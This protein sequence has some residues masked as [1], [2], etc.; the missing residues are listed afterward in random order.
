MEF[1][2][3][4]PKPEK[5]E[6][7]KQKKIKTNYN[8][9]RSP[10]ILTDLYPYEKGMI[11]HEIYHGRKNREICCDLGLWVWLWHDTGGKK[12]NSLG[13]IEDHLEAHKCKEFHELLKQQGQR[14]FEELYSREEFIKKIGRNY[15]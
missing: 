15:L 7:K 10:S 12:R 5:K 13:M 14:R 4:I 6:K 8:T 2:G 11:A 9:K 3:P 1:R